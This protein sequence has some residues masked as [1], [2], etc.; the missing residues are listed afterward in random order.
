MSL[1]E[2]LEIK[3]AS[4]GSTAKVAAH[5][6]F[7]CYE[8]RAMVGGQVVD[9]LDSAPDFAQGDH[10]PSGHGIPLLFPYPNRIR[11]GR[12]SWGGCEYSL[13][14]DAV[15]YN[16]GN[17]IHGLCIDRPWR[18]AA[19]GGHYV[20]GQF[21]LSADA[22]DRRAC[23]PA[24]FLIEVRYEVGPAALR[25]DIRI[26]NPD[27]RPLPWGFGTHPYFRLPL[28]RESDPK[29]CLIEVP[30]AEEWELVDCLPTGKRR[31]VGKGK[32]LRDGEYFPGLKLDDVLTGLTVEGDAV[33]SLI[34]DEKSG[35]QVT[36]RAD[37]VFR[38]LVIY[39]PADRNAICLEPYTCATDAINLSA[40]G[41][42]AGWR[43][44][45]P[46]AEFATW[47]EIRAGRVIA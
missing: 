47:I 27:D 16:A 28:S 45:Q 46:G 40:R 13:S 26:V 18:V 34:M 36:Q 30:A 39:T 42:N 21:Q 24:D 38:E 1:M 32:D 15:P 43:V 5:L 17:A 19:R 14:T 22:P 25:A 10:K 6:G 20:V 29:H 4:T 33:E 23:W 12:F 44:L 11:G 31:R 8:F 41:I 2:P 37:A 7:N 35:L 3:D 9:V